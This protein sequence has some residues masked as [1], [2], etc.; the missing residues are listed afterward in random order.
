M[1]CNP[2]VHQVFHLLSAGQ[3][4]VVCCCF[5]HILTYVIHIDRASITRRAMLFVIDLFFIFY[6]FIFFNYLPMHASNK[7]CSHVFC[8]CALS[9]PWSTFHS[10]SWFQKVRDHWRRVKEPLSYNQNIT[11]PPKGAS[12]CSDSRL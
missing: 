9:R 2:P 1:V 3:F 11:A 5:V 8:A 10:E 7:S 4:A 6:L 12:L